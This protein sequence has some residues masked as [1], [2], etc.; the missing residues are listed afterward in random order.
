MRK[1]V[2]DTHSLLWHIFQSK[3]LSK[4]SSAIF[5][6]ADQGQ[7]TIF[8]PAIVLVEIV[9][10]MD[11]FRIS[12][13]AIDRVINLLD[14]SVVNYRLSPITTKTIRAL[15]TVPRDL[16]PDMPD[17]IIAATAVELDLPLITSDTKIRQSK[18]V[19]SVW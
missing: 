13:H 16:V 19:D 17:R 8:I 4:R 18:I 12:Q 11:K 14:E 15:Q 2:T 10:L 1:Y 6:K 9:Y 7:V 3:R 5:E